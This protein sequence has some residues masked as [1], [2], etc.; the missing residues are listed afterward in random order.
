MKYPGSTRLDIARRRWRTLSCALILV[1]IIHVVAP[2]SFAVTYRLADAEVEVQ[3]F[4]AQVRRLV[5][6][7]EYLGEPLSQAERQALERAAGDEN[8]A[9][10]VAGM[11][12]VLDA[13][14]AQT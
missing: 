9:R 11:R 6:A 14:I 8:E 3:P 12:E 1:A 10:G 13:P 4:A 2:V 7:M 5:E